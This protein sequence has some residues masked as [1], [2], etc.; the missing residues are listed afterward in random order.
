[1]K[2]NSIVIPDARDRGAT[3]RVTRHPEQYKVVLSHWRGRL[4]VAS[5]PIELAEIPTLVGVLVEALG[6]AAA[7]P[8]RPSS[9]QAGFAGVVAAVRR[10]LRPRLA[11]I[12]EL[13]AP[14]VPAAKERVG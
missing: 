5:T 13:R 2:L 11:Q 8:E 7:I 12:R 9:E 1:M 10:W 6:E 3:L 14:S 4:C